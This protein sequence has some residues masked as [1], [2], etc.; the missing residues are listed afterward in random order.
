MLSPLA[1]PPASR[2]PDK[3]TANA[4]A[5]LNCGAPM[6]PDW[7]SCNTCGQVRSAQAAQTEAKPLK[8]AHPAQ[9]APPPAAAPPPKAAP[10][11]PIKAE[12]AP[13]PKAATPPPKS[14]PA[15]PA[16]PTAPAGI[17]MFYEP[18]SVLDVLQYASH[19]M[20]SECAVPLLA[21]LRIDV[22][23]IPSRWRHVRQ[24]LW[25]SSGG[26]GS[27]RQACCPSRCD[28]LHVHQ[29]CCPG[30]CDPGRCDPLHVSTNTLCMHAT[31]F[32]CGHSVC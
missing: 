25:R 5:C 31:R 28:P 2:T 29:A 1:S 15:P 20:C 27:S 24:T 18:H 30:R 22:L 9:D 10:A 21:P 16:K 12:P 3:S 13:P 23:C 14:D 26:P 32:C 6:K 11:P 8:I 19:L 7:S 4:S 17:A